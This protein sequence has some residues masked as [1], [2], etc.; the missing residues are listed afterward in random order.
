[1]G[2]VAVEA[3]GFFGFKGERC[4]ILQEQ[5]GAQGDVPDLV[6]RLERTLGLEGVSFAAVD[7]V[8]AG[9]RE[10][11]GSKAVRDLTD[12][13]AVRVRSILVDFDFDLPLVDPEL[14]VRDHRRSVGSG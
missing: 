13:D 4:H 1:M 11:V 9:Q 5:I 2:V 10:V 3:F 6:H 12:G 7:H 8:P 14:D